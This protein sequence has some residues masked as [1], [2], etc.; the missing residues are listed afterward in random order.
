MK[1]W[2]TLLIHRHLSSLH[3]G[4]CSIVWKT[5]G[6]GI[7]TICWIREKQNLTQDFLLFVWCSSKC[8]ATKTV[9]FL[10]RYVPFPPVVS[11]WKQKTVRAMSLSLSLF[12]YLFVR[13]HVNILSDGRWI[14]SS[15]L[16]FSLL[17]QF[18][19]FRTL[20]WQKFITH[21]R[22]EETRILLFVFDLFVD[23]H[24]NVELNVIRNFERYFEKDLE[25]VRVKEDVRRT[26]V[27]CNEVAFQEMK[28]KRN[29]WRKRQTNL[30]RWK[31]P[32]KIDSSTDLHREGIE[33]TRFGIGD[34]DSS[35]VASDWNDNGLLVAGELEKEN[36]MRKNDQKFVVVVFFRHEITAC[37]CSKVSTANLLKLSFQIEFVVDSTL[38]SCEYACSFDLED[39]IMWPML[40]SMMIYEKKLEDWFHLSI[41]RQEKMDE[42]HQWFHCKSMISMMLD[43]VFETVYRLISFHQTNRLNLHQEKLHFWLMMVH[44]NRWSVLEQVEKQMDLFVV[45][46]NRSFPLSSVYFVVFEDAP[47][48]LISNRELKRA[49]FL[50]CFFQERWKTKK[51][52][53]TNVFSRCYLFSTDA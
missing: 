30:T 22:D 46:L 25:N 12:V 47:V 53:L 1:Q 43:V 31:K 11:P 37:W 9:F 51:K 13:L 6:V 5:R 8:Q 28:P 27:P 14:F 17:F 29:D 40:L 10:Y 32:K 23:L 41:D 45:V 21:I 7:W 49:E 48:S 35:A 50:C 44:K 26:L 38:L 36:R 18:Y 3:F 42:A 2:K 4:Q 34:V 24:Q 16:F 52:S 33:T 39:V 20:F 15:L 19:C